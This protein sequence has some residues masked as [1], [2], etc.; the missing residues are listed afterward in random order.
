[1]NTSRRQRKPDD[2]DDTIIKV[3]GAQPD[4]DPATYIPRSVIEDRRL[5]PAALGLLCYLFATPNASEAELQR[6][7]GSA[8]KLRG[9]LKELEALGYSQVGSVRIKGGNTVG[10]VTRP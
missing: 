4:S 3:I 6:Q 8:R 9:L 2:D 7:A 1:M 10:I 5:S